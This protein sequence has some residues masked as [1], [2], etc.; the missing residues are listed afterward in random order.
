V[1][2]DARER[3]RDHPALPC[4]AF[5]AAE[6]IGR[7]WDASGDVSFAARGC[8]ID[9][10]EEA[11]RAEGIDLVERDTPLRPPHNPGADNG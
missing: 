7:K 1:L 8:A 5:D 2:C 3:W 4:L 11:A 10:M 9:L 6:S